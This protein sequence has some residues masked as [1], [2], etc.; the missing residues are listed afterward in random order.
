MEESVIFKNDDEDMLIIHKDAVT[1][2]ELIQIGRQ[3]G[4]IK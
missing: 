1:V 3:L 4:V 2:E